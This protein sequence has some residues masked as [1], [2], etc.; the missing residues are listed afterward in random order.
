MVALIGTAAFTTEQ[1]GSTNGQLV[2][3][4]IVHFALPA[5]AGFNIS[6]ISVPLGAGDTIATLQTKFLAAIDAEAQRLGIATPT[7]VYGGAVTKLR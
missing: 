2:Y 7:A 1:D 6:T 3:E 5:G 4:G